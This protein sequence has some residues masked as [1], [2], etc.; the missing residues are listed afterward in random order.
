VLERAERARTLA[1]LVERL[2][3]RY[4]AAVVLRH[5]EGLGYGEI[6]AI[7]GQPVG[8]TKANVHRGLA[9]LRRG[10]EAADGKEATR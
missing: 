3:G 2:P 8:T 7:L 1:R 9:V 10:L 6:A 4:R 5:V